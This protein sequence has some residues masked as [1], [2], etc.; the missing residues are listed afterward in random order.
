VKYVSAK[1]SDLGEAMKS[2]WAGVVLVV[3]L[4]LG[5]VAAGCGGSTETVTETVTVEE[6]ASGGGAGTEAPESESAAD[7][8]EETSSSANAIPDGVWKLD[9]DYQPGLYRAPGGELC[10]WAKL[11][12]ANPTTGIIE[13]GGSESVQTLEID[14]PF[15]ETEGCGGW[16]PLEESTEANPSKTGI[17]DGVWQLDT[18]YQP[19]LYRAPG[20][21]LCYWATLKKANPTTSIIENGGAESTQTLEID[22]PFFET[23]GC[24]E[25]KPIG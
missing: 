16:V 17:P 13:N 25:W 12:S 4:C 21:E 3:L 14:S 9:A 18:D 23:E 20:G 10:Y 5:L 11:K 8:E 1:Q 19:G 7:R 2:G 6:E 22:S 24:G 15:F